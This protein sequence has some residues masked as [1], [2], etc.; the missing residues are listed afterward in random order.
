MVGT[1]TT[2]EGEA[3]GLPAA[4]VAWAVEAGANPLN[5]VRVTPDPA[6]T[7]DPTSEGRARTRA[8]LRT[9]DK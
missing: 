5:W 1:A 6:V 7:F 9:K 2:P 3:A 4:G 8:L